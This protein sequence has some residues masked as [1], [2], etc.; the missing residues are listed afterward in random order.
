M[1]LFGGGTDPRGKHC[2]AGFD[3]VGYRFDD[4]AQMTFEV[5][6][7]FR[8]VARRAQRRGKTFEGWLERDRGFVKIRR[9]SGFVLTQQ[10]RKKLDLGRRR[11]PF[12]LK[13]DGFEHF[14]HVRVSGEENCR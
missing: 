14:E 1:E 13:M 8:E 11:C 7:T 6:C 4:A 12:E 9:V 5:P 3:L 10:V 2:R